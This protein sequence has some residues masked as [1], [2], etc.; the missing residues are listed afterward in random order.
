MPGFAKSRYDVFVGASIYEMMLPRYVKLFTSSMDLPLSIMAAVLCMFILSDLVLLML[1]SR[2]VDF[3]VTYKA[4]VFC[5]MCWNWWDKRLTSSAKSR[6]SF[7]VSVHWILLGGDIDVL[8]IQSMTTEKMGGGGD[9]RH[10]WRTPVSTLKD[11]DNADWWMTW[12]LVF[13]YN[14]WI[15]LTILME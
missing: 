2:P 14:P 13:L 1:I 11:G 8:I 3:A 12:H 6:S 9:R 7:V 10:P 15:L 5:W 4:D